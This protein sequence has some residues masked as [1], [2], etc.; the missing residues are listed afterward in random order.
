MD[1]LEYDLHHTRNRPAETLGVELDITDVKSPEQEQ[2]EAIE[3]SKKIL[4]VLEDKLKSH[5]S[6]HSKRIKLLQAF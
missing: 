5:N 4:G 2:S 6:E 1:K 3:F